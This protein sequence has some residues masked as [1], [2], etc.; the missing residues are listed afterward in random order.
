MAARKPLTT[1]YGM[2]RAT[3]PNPRLPSSVATA[4]VAS[5]GGDDQRRHR[6]EGPLR[7]RVGRAGRDRGRGEGEDDGD[8]VLR[9][10]DRP[11]VAEDD[12]ADGAHRDAAEQRQRD[13]AV[14]ERRQ[15]PLIDDGGERDLQRD[16]HQADHDGRRQGADD[17]ERT[18][19]AGLRCGER[20]CRFGRPR[21][22]RLGSPEPLPGSLGEER[23]TRQ[24]R[25]RG[26]PVDRIRLNRS[27]NGCPNRQKATHC[28][29]P[30][31]RPERVSAEAE[32]G[33]ASPS[34]CSPR[35]PAWAGAS[36]TR[37]RRAEG[38]PPS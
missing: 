33:W 14:E 24:D 36:K 19:H 18:G 9:L 25:G 31:R 13:A 10:G 12:G 32:G 15:R 22:P 11:A 6:G 28:G 20:Q 38:T 30:V 17:A 34:A 1:G 7:R 8:R 3:A 2:K 16:R 29:P 26:G 4:A 27:G 21:L 23:R 35:A 5:G 37:L